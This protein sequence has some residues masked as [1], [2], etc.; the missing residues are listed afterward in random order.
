VTLKGNVHFNIAVHSGQLT[1]R[2][3]ERERGVGEKG[4]ERE[5]LWKI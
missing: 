3:R 1:Q 2:E 4:R 5:K